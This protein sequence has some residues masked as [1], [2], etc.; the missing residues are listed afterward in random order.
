LRTSYNQQIAGEIA[1]AHGDELVVECGA[2]TRLR[3]FEVQLEGKRRMS[4]RDFIN[5]MRVRAGERLGD[6]S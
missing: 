1:L 6:E 4:A 5:G 2:R 3:L